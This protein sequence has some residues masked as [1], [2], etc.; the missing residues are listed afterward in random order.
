MERKK[1]ESNKNPPTR[2]YPQTLSVAL[3]SSFTLADFWNKKFV[4]DL[5]RTSCGA[6]DPNKFLCKRR[7]HT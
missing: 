2:S 4:V 6:L 7:G 5:S 3:R 1:E